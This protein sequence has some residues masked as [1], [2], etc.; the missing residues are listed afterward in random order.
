LDTLCLQRPEIACLYRRRSEREIGLLRT[1]FASTHGQSLGKVTSISLSYRFNKEACLNYWVNHHTTKVLL[2][3][4]Q[5]FP[6]KMTIIS[7]IIEN[8]HGFKHGK[9]PFQHTAFSQYLRRNV[10]ANVWSRPLSDGYICRS[11]TDS[12]IKGGESHGAIPQ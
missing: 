1:N 12:F 5:P 9:R 4:S 3:H 10:G 8:W 7:G 6:A 11:V 2:F